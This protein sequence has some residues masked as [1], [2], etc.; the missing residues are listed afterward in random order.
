MLFIV[1]VQISCLCTQPVLLAK[2]Y[3]HQRSEHIPGASFD[4]ICKTLDCVI[5]PLFSCYLGLFNQGCLNSS[6]PPK[7]ACW[8]RKKRT[9]RNAHKA[10]KSTLVSKQKHHSSE[11]EKKIYDYIPWENPISLYPHHPPCVGAH[12]YTWLNTYFCHP[13]VCFLGCFFLSC[14]DVKLLESC[15]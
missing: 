12:F 3:I 9:E 7:T 14:K 5:S 2:I 1:H 10:V 15:N 11:K 6:D 4:N 13:G 8:V